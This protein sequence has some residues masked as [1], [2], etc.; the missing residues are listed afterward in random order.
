MSRNTTRGR[1]H[2]WYVYFFDDSNKLLCGYAKDNKPAK[3]WLNQEITWLQGIT[4]NLFVHYEMQEVCH[5][6]LYR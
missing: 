1:Q 4:D 2:V 5:P 3:R 6:E